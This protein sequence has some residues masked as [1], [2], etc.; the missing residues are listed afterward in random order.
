MAAAMYRSRALDEIA[1][2]QRLLD[3]HSVRDGRCMAC[4]RDGP[5]ADANDA[6][7]FLAERGLL[8]GQ[9]SLLTCVWRLRFGLTRAGRR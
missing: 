8:T 4:G 5:C 6:A 3:T 1:A 2:Q 9:P 7:N